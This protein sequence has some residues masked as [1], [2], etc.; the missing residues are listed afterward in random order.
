MHRWSSASVTDSWIDASGQALGILSHGF[1]TKCSCSS[2]DVYK[3]S[4]CSSRYAL[5]ERSK[6]SAH[7]DRSLSQTSRQQKADHDSV[8]TL[9]ARQGC[10]PSAAVSQATTISGLARAEGGIH[11][12]EL[13]CAFRNL[14][15]VNMTERLL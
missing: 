7:D 11:V 1:L 8:S 3:A 14:G 2:P 5:G 4:R 10:K 13:H 9:L 12:E 15:I 6:S